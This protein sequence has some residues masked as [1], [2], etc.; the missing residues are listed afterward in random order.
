MRGAA[1]IL[2]GLSRECQGDFSMQKITFYVKPGETGKFS[3]QRTLADNGYDIEIRELSDEIWTA[4]LLRPFFNNKPV[5]EWFDPLAQKVLS[6]AVDPKA[7][8]AQGALVAMSVDPDLIRTPLV[9]LAGRC[10]AG[11]TEAEWPAFLAGRAAPSPEPG[12]ISEFHMQHD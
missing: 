8:H 7:M 4:A 1:P 6:G 12:V 5:A 2:L 10:G 9:K 11:L 3:Q